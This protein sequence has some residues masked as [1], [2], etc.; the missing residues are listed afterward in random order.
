ME[1]LRDELQELKRQYATVHLPSEMLIFQCKRSLIK[2][3]NESH[4]EGVEEKP[5]ALEERSSVAASPDLDPGCLSA[6]VSSF[7]SAPMLPRLFHVSMM[8]AFR[9]V[10]EHSND[11]T[12]QRNAAEECSVRAGHEPYNGDAPGRDF[13]VASAFKFLATRIERR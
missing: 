1:N 11:D 6:Q 5:A 3:R 7:P 8:S 13:P 2:P 12:Q 10:S 4:G 9:P